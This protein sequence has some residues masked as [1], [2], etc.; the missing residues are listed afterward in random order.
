MLNDTITL[1]TCELPWRGVTGTPT[2]SFQVG[3]RQVVA[4]S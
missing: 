4:T 1:Q 2:R 3:S